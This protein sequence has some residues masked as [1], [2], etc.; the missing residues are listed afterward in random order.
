MGED[1]T[2]AELQRRPH[3]WRGYEPQEF[4]DVAVADGKVNARKELR[5]LES[6]RFEPM[7]K[8]GHK[9]FSMLDR[10]EM[11]EFADRNQ[12]LVNWISVWGFLEDLRYFEPYHEL[13]YSD[14]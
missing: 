3:S 2:I 7:L 4:I 6:G 8:A 14:Y 9:F 12:D 5:T 10:D 13:D 11:E 1:I